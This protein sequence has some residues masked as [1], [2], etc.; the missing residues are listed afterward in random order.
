M[1]AG[2]GLRQIRCRNESDQD[3][4]ILV[5]LCLGC[6][7]RAFV[8]V[9][10]FRAVLRVLLLLVLKAAGMLAGPLLCP[11]DGQADDGESIEK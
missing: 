8:S 1:Q 6:M 4:T 5:K 2:L 3:H 11:L 10:A 9:A 7:R